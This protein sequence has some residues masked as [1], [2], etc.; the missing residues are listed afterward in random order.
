MKPGDCITTMDYGACAHAV[1]HATA[2]RVTTEC[3]IRFRRARLQYNLGR[4]EPCESCAAAMERK[5]MRGD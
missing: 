4:R 5:V 2:A 3:G 1:A